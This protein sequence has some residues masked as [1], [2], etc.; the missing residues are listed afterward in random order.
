MI[1]KR[2]TV[3]KDLAAQSQVVWEKRMAFADLKRKFPGLHDKLDE[4]LL[5]DKERPTKKPDAVYV[6]LMLQSCVILFM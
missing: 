1:L 6:L 4:E 2:E 3:K 5:V